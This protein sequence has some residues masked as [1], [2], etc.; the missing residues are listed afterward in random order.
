MLPND[1][2]PPSENKNKDI[3][4]GREEGEEVNF[5]LVVFRDKLGVE[6]IDGKEEFNTFMKS[7]FDDMTNNIMQGFKLFSIQLGGKMAIGSS[8]SSHHEEKNTYGETIFSK[9]GPH[10]RPHDFKNYIKSTI[11]KF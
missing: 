9:T 7:Y 4:S 1:Y 2:L 11:Y 6:V 8:N 10:N 5:A 3:V